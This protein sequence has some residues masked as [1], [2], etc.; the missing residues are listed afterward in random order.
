MILLMDMNMLW[1]V[2]AVWS[3]LATKNQFLHVNAQTNT[4]PEENDLQAANPGNPPPQTSTVADKVIQL[5]QIA[6]LPMTRGFSA[7]PM[8]VINDGVLSNFAVDQRGFIWEILDIGPDPTVPFLDVTNTAVLGTSTGQTD[9][10]YNF[11]ENRGQIGLSSAAFHPDF[12]DSAQPGYRKFYTAAAHDQVTG[13]V[14]DFDTTEGSASHFSVVHE[15]DLNTASPTLVK[16]VLAIKQTCGDHN[17]GKISF[18]SG[19]VPQDDDYGMLYIAMGDGGCP[20]DPFAKSQDRAF[21]LGAMLRIDPLPDDIDQGY[22]APASNPFANSTDPSEKIIYAY[23]LRNPHFFAWDDVSTTLVLSDIGQRYSEEINIIE[24]GGNYGWGKREGIHQICYGEPDV[25]YDLPLIDLDANGN[26]YK[27]PTVIYNHELGDNAIS[28]GFV[29]RGS[30]VPGLE[31]QYVLGDLASGHMFVVSM[32][33]LLTAH[34]NQVQATLQKLRIVDSGGQEVFY[35]DLVDSLTRTDL[36]FGQGHDAEIYTVSKQGGYI[37]KIVAAYPDCSLYLDGLCDI[38]FCEDCPLKCQSCVLNNGVCNP[39][40]N[41]CESSCGSGVCD[42]G[43]DCNT[44][45]GDCISGNN[46]LCGNDKCDPGEDCHNCSTDCNGQT[47]GKPSDRF[48][49]AGDGCTAGQ[50]VC[51]DGTNLLSYCCGDGSCDAG[52]TTTNCAIDCDD[53]SPPPSDCAVTGEKAL[54]CGARGNARD[55]CCSGFACDPTSTKGACRPV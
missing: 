21:P 7:R 2:V 34:I 48:C 4:C 33:N 20:V 11:V 53:D 12:D 28:G 6:Q 13:A 1:R 27:Y 10:F 39:V 15:F 36:R 25:V 22:S 54:E 45:P 14:V 49:C 41:Q 47:N 50:C 31:G 42:L 51:G 38:R 3:F 40:T 19:A 9:L 8:A 44:C 5:Q 29:Y 35:Q 16:K 24:A 23:G 52:E 46:L 55:T 43:E 32:D 26:S 18:R 17:I 30:Q 37:F